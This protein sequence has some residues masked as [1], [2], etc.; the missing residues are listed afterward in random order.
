VLCRASERTVERLDHAGIQSLV[1]QMVLIPNNLATHFLGEVA[2]H[3]RL[4]AGLRG[5]GSAAHEVID[6]ILLSRPPRQ[7]VFRRRATHADRLRPDLRPR[8]GSRPGITRA[9]S[10]SGHQAHTVTTT[11]APKCSTNP[12]LP[13]PGAAQLPRSPQ[14]AL[15][16]YVRSLQELQGAGITST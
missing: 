8:S 6:G 7:R 1:L 14:L 5:R 9:I 16:I 4:G 2:A 11:T 10:E 15:L 12:A 3:A 13:H